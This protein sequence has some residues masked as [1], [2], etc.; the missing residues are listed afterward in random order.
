MFEYVSI[1]NYSSRYRLSP[2]CCALQLIFSQKEQTLRDRCEIVRPRQTYPDDIAVQ[3]KPACAWMCQ[4]YKMHHTCLYMSSILQPV[5][6][7]YEADLQLSVA[8]AVLPH[9]VSDDCLQTHAYASRCLSCL[10]SDDIMSNRICLA[11]CIQKHFI[12]IRSCRPVGS[13]RSFICHGHK[14]CHVFP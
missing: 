6:S 9:V 7:L 14:N 5:A 4:L 11:V 13:G 3:L 12:Y 8:R 1:R 10:I 2:Q